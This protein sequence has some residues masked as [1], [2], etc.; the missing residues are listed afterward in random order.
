MESRKE[1]TNVVEIINTKGT[2]I[3]KSEELSIVAT[4]KKEKSKKQKKC[5]Y[6][7]ENISVVC[8]TYAYS[9]THIYYIYIYDFHRRAASTSSTLCKS[10]I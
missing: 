3:E 5:E 9:H 1:K 2:L 4:K 10:E 7:N 8:N 6:N